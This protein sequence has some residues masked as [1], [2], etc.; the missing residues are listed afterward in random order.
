MTN[1]YSSTRGK[2][3]APKNVVH[4]RVSIVLELIV[5]MGCPLSKL[6]SSNVTV[7]IALFFTNM[8]FRYFRW[9]TCQD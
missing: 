7:D 8:T 3:N 1:Y 5:P 9:Y 2:L 6:Y 4:F